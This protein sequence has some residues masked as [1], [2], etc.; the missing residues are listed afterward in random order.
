MQLDSYSIESTSNSSTKSSI[1]EIASSILPL[2][3]F[4]LSLIQIY[5]VVWIEWVFIFRD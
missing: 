4:L 1:L 5:D 2:K 3:T